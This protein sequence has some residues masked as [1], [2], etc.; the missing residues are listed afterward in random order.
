MR[1]MSFSLGFARSLSFLNISENSERTSKEPCPP[2]PIT[3]GKPYRKEDQD[4]PL[5]FGLL[6]SVQ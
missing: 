6:S 5:E 1:A 2:T 3:G 4:L